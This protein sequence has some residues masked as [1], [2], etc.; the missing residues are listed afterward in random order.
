MY[1]LQPRDPETQLRNELIHTYDEA[2]RLDGS[3]AVVYSENTR[4]SLMTKQR[5]LD[6]T[7][8]VLSRVEAAQT[9]GATVP[10]VDAW[11]RKGMLKGYGAGKDMVFLPADV[12]ALKQKRGENA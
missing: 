12:Q 11:V 5:F 1:V 2:V 9:L 10:N 3:V 4:K 7:D 8:Q 6:I